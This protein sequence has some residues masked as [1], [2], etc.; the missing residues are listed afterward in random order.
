MVNA[1]I[2]SAV[3]YIERLTITGHSSPASFYVN[4]LS[5][6]QR[7]YP[8]AIEGA[9]NMTRDRINY[10]INQKTIGVVGWTDHAA[11]L[12]RRELYKRNNEFWDNQSRIQ[13]ENLESEIVIR[14]TEI[15][16]LETTMTRYVD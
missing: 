1:F 9:R 5:T 7:S 3:N 10:E 15:D 13:I 6:N 4:I 8:Y 11:N 12:I 2:D 16:Q 14:D